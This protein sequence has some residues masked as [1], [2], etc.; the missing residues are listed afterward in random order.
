MLFLSPVVY[1]W[2][3]APASIVLAPFM[4][5]FGGLE[6]KR[7]AQAQKAWRP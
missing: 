3:E 4:G 7:F 2:V 5:L 6:A 1:N